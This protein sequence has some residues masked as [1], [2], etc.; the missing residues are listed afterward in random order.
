MIPFLSQLH[1][2]AVVDKKILK[3]TL[4]ILDIIHRLIIYLKLNSTL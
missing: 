4:T 1:C 2:Y 3:I